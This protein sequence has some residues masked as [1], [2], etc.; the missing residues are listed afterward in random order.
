MVTEENSDNSVPH[1]GIKSYGEIGGSAVLTKKQR[2]YFLDVSDVEA[3]SAT[4]RALRARIRDRLSRSVA[5][6][7]L[8]HESMESR[9]I[10]TVFEP[11]GFSNTPSSERGIDALAIMLDGIV[12]STE[13][14]DYRIGETP[15]DDEIR[16]SA[17]T[18]IAEA[19][20][21]VYGRH[22]FDIESVEVSID[23]NFRPPVDELVKRP[24]DEVSIKQ[25]KQL[26]K[27]KEIT[28]DEF[29][30]FVSILSGVN[31]DEE[32]PRYQ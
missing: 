25:Y 10:E 9:D 7:A 20:K 27:E 26:L 17:E 11:F 19:I 4:E 16:S 31:P 28:E 12:R 29:Y 3:K 23:P 13:I 22:G 30:K 1:I 15:K 6:L 32:E 18:V 8:L 21:N 2:E 24:P 5:D 14:D